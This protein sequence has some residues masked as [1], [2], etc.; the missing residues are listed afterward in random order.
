[1]NIRKLKT[2]TQMNKEFTMKKMLTV[3]TLFLSFSTLASVCVISEP[4]VKGSSDFDKEMVLV[5]LDEGFK[6][7]L[8]K[9]NGT[10]VKNIK[11]NQKILEGTRLVYIGKISGEK[12]RITTVSHNPSEEFGIMAILSLEKGK[13]QILIDFRNELAF[14]CVL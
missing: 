8:I 12:L 1:V 3:I 9:P 10:V 13:E 7:L 5:N 2:I 11:E 14:N 6:G 4:S